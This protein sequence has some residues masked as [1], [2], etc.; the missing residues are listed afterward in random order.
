MFYSMRKQKKNIHKQKF[1]AR[2]KSNNML[3]K[4]IFR[5]VNKSCSMSAI[6]LSLTFHFDKYSLFPNSIFVNFHAEIFWDVDKPFYLICITN[7]KS[8]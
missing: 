5:L 1:V 2:S 6:F 4:Y 7:N 3:K 8:I